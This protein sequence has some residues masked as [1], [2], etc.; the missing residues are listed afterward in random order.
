LTQQALTD[1]NIQLGGK[2]HRAC[3]KVGNPRMALVREERVR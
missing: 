3:A 2:I 1:V